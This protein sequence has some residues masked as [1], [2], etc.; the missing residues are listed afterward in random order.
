MGQPGLWEP[1]RVPWKP[2]GQLRVRRGG[3]RGPGLERHLSPSFLH[4]CVFSRLSEQHVSCKRERVADGWRAGSGPPA[5][6]GGAQ[7][8]DG[9]RGLEARTLR[10]RA[11]CL[12]PTPPGTT[13]HPGG[14][15]S[16]ALALNVTVCAVSFQDIPQRCCFKGKFWKFEDTPETLENLSKRIFKESAWLSPRSPRSHG[17]STAPSRGH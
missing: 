17:A 11:P 10:T 9:A 16:T 14:R 3:C 4:R 15:G 2:R 6:Q 12:P 7:R 13:P 1:W 5:G 8:L